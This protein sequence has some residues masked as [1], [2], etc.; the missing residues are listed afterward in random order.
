MGTPTTGDGEAQSGVCV[1]GWP[2]APLVGADQ[3][4]LTTEDFLAALDENLA[5]ELA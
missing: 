3:E 5:A 2:P 1:P 4:F